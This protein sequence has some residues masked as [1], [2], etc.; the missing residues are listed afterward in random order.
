MQHPILWNKIFSFSSELHP[1]YHDTLYLPYICF[2]I[3]T[4]LFIFSDNIVFLLS[5][6]CNSSDKLRSIYLSKMDLT[7][8][9]YFPNLLCLSIISCL[10][11]IFL[12]NLEVNF[13][14]GTYSWEEDVCKA[15]TVLIPYRKIQYVAIETPFL[16]VIILIIT[17]LLTLS[18]GFPSHKNW[19]K[20]SYIS[21][22]TWAE[23]FDSIV[24]IC[25]KSG[26]ANVLI[27]VIRTI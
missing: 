27:T 19:Y 6:G 10:P 25:T 2:E 22:K 17:V 15:N 20:M 24:K 16:I 18:S 3:M 12:Y 4:K 11:H 21:V 14:M 8:Q 9:I 7:C 5:F 23:G 13:S 26:R 1:Q